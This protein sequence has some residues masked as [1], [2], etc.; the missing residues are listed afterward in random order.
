MNKFLCCTFFAIAASSLAHAEGAY[1]GA[2]VAS[3]GDS[4]IE[5]GAAGTPSR[6]DATREQTQLRFFGGYE[7]DQHWGLEAGYHG[8]GGST[9]FDADGARL[10][11]RTRV[12]Y[13][14]AKGTWQLSEDWSLFAKAGVARS[15]LQM[16]LS[17]GSNTAATSTSRTGAYLSAGASWLVTRDVALQVELERINKLRYQGLELG[18]N[19]LSLGLRYNF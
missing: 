11:L 16:D 13:A 18:M 17:S 12:L 3:A 1:V 14:A 9:A 10:K 4:H 2:A 5:V 6:H 19:R 15:R 8:L 7:L